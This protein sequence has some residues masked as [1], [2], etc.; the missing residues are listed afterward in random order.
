M[1]RALRFGPALVWALVIFLLSHQPSGAFPSVPL[2]GLDKI[3]HAVAYGVL[4][5]LLAFG[6]GFPVRAPSWSWVVAVA[7]YG[8]SDEW[9]QTF[10][11]GRSWETWDLL[12]D[13]GGSLLALAWARRYSARR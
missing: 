13:A 12:A 4:A 2:P 10:V 5:L 1:A 7:A 11:P 3:A 8:V 6:A 9:H